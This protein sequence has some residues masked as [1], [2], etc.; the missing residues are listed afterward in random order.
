[1]GGGGRLEVQVRT[2]KGMDDVE[3]K[4]HSS[5]DSEINGGKPDL[6]TS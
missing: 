5:F 1:V 2:R 3:L 4:P 6:W